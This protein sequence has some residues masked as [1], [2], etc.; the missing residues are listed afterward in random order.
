MKNNEV[1]AAV[2]VTKRI[3]WAL[4]HWGLPYGASS[5]LH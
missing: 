3:I 1:E 2:G 5:A 4:R